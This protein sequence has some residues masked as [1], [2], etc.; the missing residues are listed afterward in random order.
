MAVRK[1]ANEI[2][3]FREVALR[4][5][6]HYGQPLSEAQRTEFV[7]LFGDLLE[8]SY[9]SKIAL[10]GGEK[11]LYSGERMDGGLATV[12]TKIIIRRNRA[13]QERQENRLQSR[14]SLPA[15]V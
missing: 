8:R 1:I 10:Y 11:I 13:R 7:G 5:L 15:R 6:G 12:S 3:D 14:S 4:S 9:I 2:V